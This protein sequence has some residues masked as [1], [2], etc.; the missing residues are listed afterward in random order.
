MEDIIGDALGDAIYGIFD[1]LDDSVADFLSATDGDILSGAV[2]VQDAITEAA[3]SLTDLTH[4]AGSAASLD[5][6]TDFGVP[7]VNSISESS[8]EDVDE[9]LLP[10]SNSTSDI[11]FEGLSAGDKAHQ[12]FNQ[13]LDKNNVDVPYSKTPDL[14]DGS[15]SASQRGDLENFVRDKYRNGEISAEDETKLMEK[16]KTMYW[17]H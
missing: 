13:I 16:I 8:F 17:G 4:G 11:S 2:D 10:Q 12:E 1:N 15:I 5:G 14:H 7:E 3:H 9:S 6:I